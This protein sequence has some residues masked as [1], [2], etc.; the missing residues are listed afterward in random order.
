[1]S[2]ARD[3][4]QQSDPDSTGR[5]I[6]IAED[7][8]DTRDA[9]RMLLEAYGFHVLVAKNG[10]EAVAR[11][12][13]LKPDLIIMD[14]MMPTMDGI[15][16]TRT[17]RGSPSFRQV[18]ILALTAMAGSREMALEAGCDD[19]LAKPIDVQSFLGKISRWL[20]VEPSRR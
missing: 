10:Q 18:P 7:N 19:W 20:G 12:I 8:L 13:D 14:I 11:G 3:P 1:V 5:S 16:A 2:I 15:Q 9:L 6:L 4:G 17:L